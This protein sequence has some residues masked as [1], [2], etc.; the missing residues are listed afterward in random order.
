MPVKT[1]LAEGDI[2]S[3]YWLALATALKSQPAQPACS[4]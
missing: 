1:D 2:P 3:L 4:G